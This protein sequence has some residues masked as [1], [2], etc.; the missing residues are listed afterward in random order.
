MWPS[1]LTYA[2]IER[3]TEETE[4]AGCKFDPIAC[5]EGNGSEAEALGEWVKFAGN[6]RTSIVVL[7]WWTFPADEK[8]PAVVAEKMTAFKEALVGDQINEGRIA[9]EK[10]LDRFSMAAGRNRFFGRLAEK[11][12]LAADQMMETCATQMEKISVDAV[13]QAA[14]GGVKSGDSP[15][16]SESTLEPTPTGS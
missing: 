2:Q 4:K 10:A 3:I 6:T 8:D 13:L 1:E 9:F 15:A 12:R 16:E 5:Y 14:G 11:V 7:F